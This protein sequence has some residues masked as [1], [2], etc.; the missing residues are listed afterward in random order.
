AAIAREELEDDDLAF[1]WLGEAL[2]A[3][4][5]EAR[6]DQ[7]ERLADAVKAPERAAEVIGQAL[8]QV[9]DGP[10]VRLL[11]ARRAELRSDKLGDR[12]GAAEDLRRIYDLSPSESGVA[13]RLQA[14]YE[15]LGDVQG[16]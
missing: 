14:L 10:L 3:Y 2:A 7:L 4:V 15:E 9:F 12:K 13:A 1:R 8:E 6:L 11:L 16:L 5:D